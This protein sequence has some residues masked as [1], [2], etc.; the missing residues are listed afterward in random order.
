MKSLRWQETGEELTT[1][2]KQYHWVNRSPFELKQLGGR[3]R[4]GYTQ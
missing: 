3:G 4:L 1:P 2:V